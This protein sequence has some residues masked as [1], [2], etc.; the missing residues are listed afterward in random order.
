MP[1]V[2][3][4]QSNFSA[5]EFSPTMEGRVDVDRYKQGLATCLNYMPTVQGGLTRRPGTKYVADVKT[6]AKKTRLVEFE[7]SVTQAYVIE[8][9]D[10]YVR[11]YKD[12]GQILDGGP[13]EVVTPYLEADLFQLKFTQSADVLYITHPSYAPRSLSRT[14]DIAWTLTTL[15][16]KDGP[17]LR[18]NDTATTMTPGAATGTG[19]TLTASAV[20]G[21]NDDTGFQTTDVGRLIR[22]QT[23]SVWGRATIASHSSTTVVTID[24][25]DTL[26]DTTAKTEWRLGI[27][28]DTTGYPAAVTFHEDR[29]TFAGV[30]DFPQRMDMSNSADYLNFRPT[31]LDSTLVDSHAL[32][33]TF[34]ANDVNVVRW[35]LSDEKGLIVGTVKGE[36]IVRPSSRGESLTP[37]NITAKRSTTYGSANVQPQQIGKAGIFVQRAGR[38][39]REL[40]FFFDVDGFRATDLT[41][42]SDHITSSGITEMAHQNEPHPIVWAVRTDG[43]LLGLTYERDVDGFKAGWHR[44]IVGGVSDAGNNDAKV[45]SVAV[46]P[47]A[48]GTR[49]ELWMVVQRYIDGAVTR[50]IEYLT[51]FFDDDVEQEDAFFVDSGLTLDSPVT[52]SGATK[53]DP[54]VITATSHGFSDGDKVLFKEVLGMTELNGSSYIVANKTTH[55]FELTNVDTAADIDG[56]GFTTYVSGGEVRK[57]VTAISGLSHLEGETVSILADGAVQSDQAVASGAITLTVS[58]T[59]VHVGLGYNSDAKILRIDAGAADGTSIGKTRRIHRFGIMMHRS[60][61][62]QL[63]PAFDRL[64]NLTFRTMAD[65]LTRAPSLFTGIRSESIDMDYDFEN[66][67]C[68]RQ[69]QPLPSTILAI[70]PQM[71]TQDR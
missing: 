39:V 60:L 26:T 9:G 62:L 14:S 63:G 54:V 1:K 17:Y 67:V 70:M 59:V 22:M 55:T 38:K 53:A 18:T 50:S 44:H 35:M 47:S 31:D 13:V 27:W 58:A 69:S 2:S 64:D 49:E 57:Y 20:T 36:W 68:W 5:G 56:T 41:V 61:G 28:S 19:V 66:Q 3:P 24:I 65:P 15:T 34:S 40:T 11:F 23:G 30:P 45:E 29:L 43:V 4:N 12:N 33:F 42:L 25:E 37:T 52:V 46:I 71:N 16:F 10:L 6:V 48:D 8:F 21:I 7:F 32:S 51:R